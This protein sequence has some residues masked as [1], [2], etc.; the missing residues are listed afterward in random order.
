MATA[1]TALELLKE[2]KFRT[3]KQWRE[4]HEICQGREGSPDF[5]WI[6][7]LCHAI[8]GDNANAEYWYRSAGQKRHSQNLELEWQHINQNLSAP[9][10]KHS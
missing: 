1:L 7:A 5:D 9:P 4:A 10:T 3:G 8:E 6:H 2:G